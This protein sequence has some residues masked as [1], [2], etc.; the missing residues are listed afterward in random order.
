MLFSQLYDAA[1]L[2]IGNPNDPS[3]GSLPDPD[4]FDVNKLQVN[5]IRMRNGG[6]LAKETKERRMRSGNPW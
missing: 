3:A 1:G 6:I 2:P 5:E 4:T